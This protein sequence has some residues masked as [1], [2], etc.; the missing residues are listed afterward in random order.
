MALN[1]PFKGFCRG[2][3][4][5]SALPGHGTAQCTTFVNRLDGIKQYPRGCSWGSRSPRLHL[6]FSEN[7]ALRHRRFHPT[8]VLETKLEATIM[9]NPGYDVGDRGY[10]R[11]LS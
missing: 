6:M 3:V 2:L 1:S 5:T 9:S 10:T 8:L 7:R 4:K 11:R